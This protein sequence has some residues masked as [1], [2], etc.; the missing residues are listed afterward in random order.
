M[1]ALVVTTDSSLAEKLTEASG[2][3]DIEFQAS[4]DFPS[5]SDELSKTK[6][7]GVV[8]DFDTL[9]AA[10]A[11]V[12]RL[13][14]N[15]T[16]GNAVIFAVASDSTRR[17]RAFQNGA[18]F[19]I[20]R[21]IERIAIRRVLDAAYDLMHR[22][23][24]R[25]F[26]CAAELAVTLILETSISALQCRTM[27][28]SSNG[29]GIQTPIPLKLAQPVELVLYLPDGFVVRA[30]GL[31]IW[32]DKHGKTGLTF[33]CHSPEMRRKL[34]LWLDSQFGDGH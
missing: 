33:N 11:A 15:R 32:D 17:D 29:M 6:F 23:R 30:A 16:N 20:Q 4:G 31:V 34:D 13:R 24:R 19:L 25:Y 9:P 21:P 18:H 22:E 27:N 14:S 2:G 3:L 8:L 26:R 1:R 12:A 28:V 5:I 10:I 7:E